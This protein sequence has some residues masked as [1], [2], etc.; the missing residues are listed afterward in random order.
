MGIFSANRVQYDIH[1]Y[2]DKSRS[3]VIHVAHHLRQQTEKQL[4]WDLLD[5]EKNTDMKL[6]ESNATWPGAAVYGF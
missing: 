6:M 3:K 2:A 4:I 1:V 5:A